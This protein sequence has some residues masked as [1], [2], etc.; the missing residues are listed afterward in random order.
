MNLQL[1]VLLNNQQGKDTHIRQIKLFGPRKKV[2]EVE[3]FGHDGG[4]SGP[5]VLR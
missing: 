1:S 2:Q 4:M 3:S 5:S